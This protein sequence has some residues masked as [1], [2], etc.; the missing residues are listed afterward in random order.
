MEV[1]RCGA[2]TCCT[3]PAL[4]A[5]LWDPNSVTVSVTGAESDVGENRISKLYWYH[6]YSTPQNF[7]AKC[8]RFSIAESI[9]LKVIPMGRTTSL[10]LSNK[11]NCLRIICNV[12]EK[13]T[14]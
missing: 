3:L 13:R 9:R 2:P 1:L 4:R 14:G 6:K 11:T 7:K 8:V 10:P 5:L 12:S